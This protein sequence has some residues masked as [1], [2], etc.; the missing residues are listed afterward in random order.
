MPGRRV[1]CATRFSTAGLNT[2]PLCRGPPVGGAAPRGCAARGAGRELELELLRVER[3]LH[4]LDDLVLTHRLIRILL[5]GLR[6]LARRVDELEAP[7]RHLVQ[8]V[9]EQ[10][11]RLRLLGALP[12]ERRLL[13]ELERERVGLE[14]RRVRL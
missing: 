7:T 5:L 2:P 11:D 6:A 4:E 12:V 10:G 13:R 3:R 14:R 1:N 9:L 8:G